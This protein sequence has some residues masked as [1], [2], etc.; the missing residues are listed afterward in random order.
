MRR[1]AVGVGVA[2]VVAAAVALVIEL[3]GIS[4]ATGSPTAR[5][6]GARTV[7]TVLRPVHADGTPAPGYRVTIESVQGFTCDEGASPSAVDPDIRVCG[8]TALNTLSCW[9]ST[10]HTVLCLR[11]AYTRSLV[12]IRY[13]GT[14]AHVAAPI[15]PAPQ[16]LTLT[17]GAHCHIRD[18]GAWDSVVSHPTWVGAYWCA[19]TSLYGPPGG[20]GIDSSV[21]PWLVHEVSGVS[22]NGTQRVVDRRV[23][24][25]FFVGTAT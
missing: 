2:V 6:T 5:A 3:G 18:G 17:T 16:G 7:Q 15:R 24:R 20:Y 11:D 10:G 12:R 23:A 22:G 1:L 8:F 21:M 25:A 14:F 13:T 9:R 19:T 4:G